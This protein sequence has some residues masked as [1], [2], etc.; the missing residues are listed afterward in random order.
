[1]INLKNKQIKN[2]KINVASGVY[3]LEDYINY[4]FSVF[5]LLSYIPIPSF[6][7]F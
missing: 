5:F 4:D 2:L 1:M 7:F 3:V 6:F